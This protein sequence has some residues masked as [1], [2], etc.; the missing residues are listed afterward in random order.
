MD[1]VIFLDQETECGKQ[2]ESEQRFKNK[3]L[4]SALE[5]LG[6]STHPATMEIV[7]FLEKAVPHLPNEVISILP[8]RT[9]EI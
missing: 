8:M 1:A 7:T 9:F 6:K 4:R 3:G 2:K 5:D